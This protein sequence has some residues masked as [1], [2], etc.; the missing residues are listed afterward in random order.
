[1]RILSGVTK[2]RALL[3]ILVATVPGTALAEQRVALIIGNSAYQNFT[4]LRNPMN[5]ANDIAASLK[6]LGFEV[7][8]GL[9]LSNA[10][11]NQIVNRF[12]EA[13]R[14]SDVS[15]FYYAGHAFQI[16]SQ[17]FLVP[18]DASIKSKKDVRQ[19]TIELAKLMKGLEGSK[20]LHLVFLDACRNNPL[21]GQGD[22]GSD[23]TRD[24]LARVGDAAGFLVAFATQPD[25][26]AYDGV[27]RNSWFSRAV[28]SHIGTQGQDI[29]SMMINV[30]RDVIAATGGQQ[31]P[32]ENSS[33]TK[34]FY[35][36]PGRA[37]AA[38]PE[39]QLWQLAASSRDPA[40]LRVYVDRYP[41][42]TYT[43]E[44]QVL[45]GNSGNIVIASN[46]P[47]STQI[48]GGGSEENLWNFTRTMRVR[49]L[50][51]YYLSRYPSGSHADEARKLLSAL[52]RVDDID[53]H[54]ELVCEV[55]AT[56][57]RD[58]TAD[59]PGVPIDLLARKADIAIDACRRAMAAHPDM[60]HYA[61]LLARALAAAQ[62]KNEA[63][64]FYRLAADRGNLRAMVSLGLMLENGD[65]LPR[66][67]KAA[68]RLYERAAV[69]GHPDGQINLAVALI[70][71][72]GVKRNVP[73]A[74]QLMKKASESGSAIATYNMGVLALNRQY[75]TLSDAIG[76][77]RKSIELGDPRGYLAAATLLDQ[78]HGT[79]NDPVAAA[80]ML[81]AGVESDSGE[82]MNA[83][84]KHPKDWSP[85]TIRAVQIR[86]KEATHYGGPINGEITGL[87]EPLARW[88]TM[89]ALPSLAEEKF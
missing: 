9:D 8:K 63:I 10:E 32:W 83:L 24:G 71:G 44:A 62:R 35:F 11:M 40:L 6:N 48:P 16:S 3:F 21:P 42:G 67:L 84:I 86:L 50:V 4:S 29:A 72:V 79:R 85:E 64:E 2:P 51:E 22:L 75:G 74:A 73:R 68:I 37:V 60:P 39:T 33:L 58:A 14:R 56:H 15:L 30:R 77:F 76:Y 27:G 20:G 61:A 53:A 28:L 19:Q 5:D 13:A 89:G 1:M 34:Q 65:G 87:K 38:S 57:P 25:R 59:T 7:M 26:A 18:I 55:N 80:E 69:G 47:R 12:I 88:R 70:E 82:A 41:A 45:L 81:L 78:G 36:S 66:D 23:A 52:P 43:R 54:P 17:N 46:D 31:V 49:P